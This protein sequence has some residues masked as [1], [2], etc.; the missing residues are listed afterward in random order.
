[1][2]GKLSVVSKLLRLTSIWAVRLGPGHLMVL[3]TA[4]LALVAEV[5]GGRVRGEARWLVSWDAGVLAYLALS[6]LIVVL[7]DSARTRRRVLRKTPAGL[8]LFWVVLVAACASAA[9]GVMM[10]HQPLYDSALS[11]G[12]H[13]GLALV[14]V[15]CAW[16]V[17]HTD[18]GFRY[19]ARYYRNERDGDR[20]LRFHAHSPPD[21]LDFMLF[22]FFYRHD[23]Q[24]VRCRDQLPRHA[25]DDDAARDHFVR[26]Q[27]AHSLHL[28][29]PDRGVSGNFEYRPDRWHFPPVLRSHPKAIASQ[30][31]GFGSP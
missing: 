12:W 19:A 6:W 30:V 10:I 22:A 2:F 4:V 3:S 15:A 8:A 16:M 24:R 26:V 11:R 20:G 28:H 9:A 14:T 25:L 13:V 18:F 17:L 21:Y 31:V 1:M 23:Q 5:T 7:L 27:L 29:Q